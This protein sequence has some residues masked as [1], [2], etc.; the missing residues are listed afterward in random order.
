MPCF[1]YQ[2]SRSRTPDGREDV[3]EL[4]QLVDAQRAQL[5]NRRAFVQAD[6]AF[7]R[8]VASISQNPI[9]LAVSQAML[10]WVFH[11]HTDLLHWSGQEEVTLEE[12]GAI[13][14]ATPAIRPLARENVS[15]SCGTPARAA[16]E[17]LADG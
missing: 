9:F 6:I 17:A 15:Q 12:H 5:G 14:D 2:Q 1:R 13:V 7:H 8:K 4:R 16:V 11:Y 10:S 3:A